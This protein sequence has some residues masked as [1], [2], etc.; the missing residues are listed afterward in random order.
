MKNDKLEEIGDKLGVS[1]NDLKNIR[2]EKQKSIII[3]PIIGTIIAILST[4][5][6]YI[7]G[8]N[9]E[10]KLVSKNTGRTYPYS[11]VCF[12]IPLVFGIG[13]TLVGLVSA[14][15]VSYSNTKYKKLILMTILVTIIISIVG[16]IIAFNLLH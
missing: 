5:M 12:G 10:P 3:Y 6:G 2:R 13:S 14:L 9:S 11:Q 4:I 8:K 16:F 7:L 15:K 1:N